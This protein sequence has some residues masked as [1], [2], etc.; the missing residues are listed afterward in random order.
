[1][2]GKRSY[3]TFSISRIKQGGRV[4]V[5]SISKQRKEK[6]KGGRLYRER[7]RGHVIDG[8]KET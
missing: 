5:H 3:L 7:E 2:C 8:E 1:M 6:R 4:E